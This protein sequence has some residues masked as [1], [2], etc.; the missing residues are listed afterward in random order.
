[1]A[2]KAKKGTDMLE[3][4]AD[5]LSEVAVQTL[6]GIAELSPDGGID[7]EGLFFLFLVTALGVTRDMDAALNVFIDMSERIQANREFFKFSL[8]ELNKGGM[9]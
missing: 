1:M 2:K 6:K 5:W 8:T 4:N 7:D 9:Q 3:N